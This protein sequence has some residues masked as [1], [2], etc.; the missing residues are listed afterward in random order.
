MVNQFS[1]NVHVLRQ[2]KLVSLIP[3]VAI[4]YSI[5]H[6]FLLAAMLRLK[7]VYEW[8]RGKGKGQ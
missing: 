2:T 1:Y 6:H 8:Y 4:K 5:F 7:T 3:V